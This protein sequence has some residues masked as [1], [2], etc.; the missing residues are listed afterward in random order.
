LLSH[1]RPIVCRA[2]QLYSVLS[3]QAHPG[4]LHPC[5]VLLV[6]G[7]LSAEEMR[8]LECLADE[9]RCPCELRYKQVPTALAATEGV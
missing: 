4:E 5:K 7:P 9:V 3:Q 8:F 2:V 6:E 1:L